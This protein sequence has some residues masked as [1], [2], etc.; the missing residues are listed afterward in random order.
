MVNEKHNAIQLCAVTSIHFYAQTPLAARGTWLIHPWLKFMFLYHSNPRPPR[1]NNQ[2]CIFERRVFETWI[3]YDNRRGGQQ[4]LVQRTCFS[5]YYTRREK[6][7]RSLS[8]QW[9]KVQRPAEAGGGGGRREG[10]EAIS[11][12]RPKPACPLSSARPELHF[13]RPVLSN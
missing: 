4:R 2:C 13:T 1:F 10:S 12:C 3:K 6:G 11:S 8:F 7:S 9:Q 5:S